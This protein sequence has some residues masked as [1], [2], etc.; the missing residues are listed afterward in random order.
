MPKIT[1]ETFGCILFYITFLRLY[2]LCLVF[3]Y[4]KNEKKLPENLEDILK[5]IT[6]ALEIRKQTP[7]GW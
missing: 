4:R 3:F 6:F 2:I 1:F 7:D 5:S